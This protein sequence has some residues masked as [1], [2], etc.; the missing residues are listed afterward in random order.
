MLGWKCKELE[1]SYGAG[2]VV[3][4]DYTLDRLSNVL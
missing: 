3:S 1:Q 4:K 2:F